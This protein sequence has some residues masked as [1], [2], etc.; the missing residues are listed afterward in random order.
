M[1]PKNPHVYLADMLP[2]RNGGGAINTVY[3][4]MNVRFLLFFILFNICLETTAL[5]VCSSGLLKSVGDID[6]RAVSVDRM[7][8]VPRKRL[9]ELFKIQSKQWLFLGSCDFCNF[10][11]CC[12]CDVIFPKINQ[13]VVRAPSVAKE[14][15][16]MSL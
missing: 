7:Q 3:I 13:G 8:I 15:L 11:S 5:Q 6:V 12:L 14:H 10:S 9:L 2:R 4:F 16:S 1:A